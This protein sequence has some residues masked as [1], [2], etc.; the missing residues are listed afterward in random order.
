DLIL[1][2]AAI[3][4]FDPMDWMGLDW[5]VVVLFW[6]ALMACVLL[7]NG[8]ES[9]RKRRAGALGVPLSDP[10]SPRW[11]KVLMG[12]VIV[13][14][15]VNPFVTGWLPLGFDMLCLATGW[16][17]RRVETG[18]RSGRGRWMVITWRWSRS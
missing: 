4:G 9:Y 13:Y 14:A 5:L 1:H 15:L 2:I 8:V 12:G 6:G 7:A 16:N 18:S 3:A 10:V 11:F 17:L